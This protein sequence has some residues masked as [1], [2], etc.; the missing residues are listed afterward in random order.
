[1]RELIRD[2]VQICTEVL[3][4]PQPVCE[5]GS[6]QVPGQEGFADLRPFFPGKRYVG[7]DSREGPGVDVILDLHDLGLAAASA[8]TA[9]ILD[10]LEHVEDPRRAVLEAHRIL[11]PGGVLLIGSVMNFK[12]HSYPHDYWRFT[13]EAFRSLLKPFPISVVDF[14]GEPRFPHTIVGV[15]AKGALTETQLDELR[16]RLGAW[17]SRWSQTG[18]PHGWQHVAKLWLPPILVNACRWLIGRGRGP[19]TQ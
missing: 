12:I 16:R 13:P 6:L 15:A 3:P 14:A 9:L 19:A 1:M 11:K 2:Y 17:R 8:G 10:T 5:F 18:R 7:A 4:T